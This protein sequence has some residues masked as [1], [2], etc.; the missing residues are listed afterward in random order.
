M[1]NPAGSTHCQKCRTMLR[2]E[3]QRAASGGMKALI[4]I[5]LFI[6]GLTAVIGILWVIMHDLLHTV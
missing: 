2:T 3:E 4:Q 6:V 5:I 1:V